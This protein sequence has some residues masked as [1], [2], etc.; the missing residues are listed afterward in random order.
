MPITHVGSSE[1]SNSGGVALTITLPAGLQQGD[2]VYVNARDVGAPTSGG[3]TTIASESTWWKVVRKVM[4]ATPDTSISFAAGGATAGSAGVASAFRGVDTTTPEDVSAVVVTSDNASSATPA[5]SDGMSVVFASGEGNTS[6][7]TPPSG[8]TLADAIGASG[9]TFNNSVATWYSTSP[10][11]AFVPVDPGAPVSWPI[12]AATGDTAHVILRE[13]AETGITVASTGSTGAASGLS[14]LSLTLTSLAQNDVVYVLAR[15]VGSITSGGWTQ[16]D[17]V[18]NQYLW[19]K[20]MGATPDTTVEMTGNGSGTVSSVARYIALRGVDTTTPED[21]VTI[22]SASSLDP[23]SITPKTTGAMALVFTGDSVNDGTVTVPTGYTGGATNQPGT[24]TSQTVGIA[25]KSGLTANTAEDP[26]AWTNWTSSSPVSR[27]L[28][29]R[30]SGAQ[31]PFAAH[32]GSLGNTNASASA[33]STTLTLTAAA[34]IGDL[35]TVAYKSDRANDTATGTGTTFH[36]TCTD[37]AGN[38]YTKVG[39]YTYDTSGGGNAS[40]AVSV[41]MSRLTA[42]LSISNTITVSHSGSASVANRALMADRFTCNGTPQVFGSVQYG[43]SETTDLPALTVS[44]LTARA[45]GYLAYRATGFRTNTTLTSGTSGWT[46]LTG[47]A[48]TTRAVDAEFRVLDSEATA[49]YSDPTAGASAANAS[50]MAVIGAQVPTAT[51]SLAATDVADTAAATGQVL[52]RGSLAAT[53]AADAAAATGRVLVQGALAATEGA[54]TAAATGSVRVQG[55]FA[56]TDAGADTAA[57]TGTV[58]VT[59]ALAATEGADTFAA[60]GEAD[61]QLDGTMDATEAPDTIAITGRVLVQGLL[62]AAEGADTAVGSGQ[63][64]VRGALAALEADDAAAGTGSVLVRGAL[65]A[66]EAADVFSGLGSVVVETAYVA[67]VPVQ[68]RTAIVPVELRTAIVA[69]QHRTAV[70]PAR[71]RTAVVPT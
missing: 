56:A 18:G 55:Q 3:W 41:W 27:T 60:A 68:P 9:S 58:L 45:D 71:P 15:G 12:T 20:V 63:I 39:E 19:R 51:G 38:T 30:A 40:Q 70:V 59:G 28:V 49:V 53:E 1:N 10:T 62:A 67:I 46:A 26:G 61:G 34:S 50:I 29:V 47:S 11:S 52:V 31:P 57:G 5:N 13:A 69:A 4:G 64:L 24:G 32:V 43:N 37:T 66:T 25:Y 35:V 7:C 14:A 17:N 22:T 48:N 23:A 65:A 21:G 36:S 2:V 6:S 42:A 16:L 33:A 54:D 8:Y 44:G